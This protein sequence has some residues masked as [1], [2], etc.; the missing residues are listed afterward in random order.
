MNEPF[1]ANDR[2]RNQVN[3][4]M[5][6]SEHSMVRELPPRYSTSVRARDKSVG[7]AKRKKKIMLDTYGESQ[8]A[9]TGR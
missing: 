8:Y 3:K 9:S 2:D 5:E 4:S 1:S 7:G 6:F